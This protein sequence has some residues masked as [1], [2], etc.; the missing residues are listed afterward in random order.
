[1]RSWFFLF[2]IAATLA[3]APGLL[4]QSADARAQRTGAE[5]YDAA[6]AACHGAD[7]RGQPVTTV[8]FDIPLPDFTDCSFASREPAED[9]LAIAHDGGP[10]RAFDRMMPAFGEAL[11]VEEIGRIVERLHEFCGDESWPRGELNLP[12]ALVTEKAFPEDEAVLTVQAAAEGPA[13]L[14]PQFIYEKRFGARNQVELAIPFSFVERAQGG[15]MGGVGDLVFAFKRDMVHSLKSGSIFSLGS[16]A[17]FPTGNA[18][19]GF[20][21]G[22]TIFEPF[23]AFGQILPANS[24]VQ[25]H[26]GF[27]LPADRDRTDEAFWRTAVGKTLTQ[28]NYGRTWTPMLEILGARELEPGTSN[29]WDLVPELQVSLSKRQ[30]ILLNVGARF[31]VTN[32]GPR[33]T[34][35]L[36][37]V[38]WDWFDGGLF[39]GW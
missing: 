12:R 13:A 18:E 25:F 37:Y 16:E 7:G 1:M 20:G 28:Q 8:G 23:A 34:Q 36:F 10:A 15:W 33:A 30:H 22:G 35:V 27:E 9:W 14:T 21:K 39:S 31:P 38:L 11:T 32:S 5:L 26:G 24:F 3:W 29:E 17:I 4:A 6:C 19:R 2:S